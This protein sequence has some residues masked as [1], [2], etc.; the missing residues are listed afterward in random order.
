MY[1]KLLL[2][3]VLCTIIK[4]ENNRRTAMIKIIA[5]DM[6]GTLLDDEKQLPSNFEDVIS[7][8]SRRKINFVISSGRSFNVLKK[9]FT[10]HIDD[11]TFICDN[12]AYIVVG[13]KNIYTSVIDRQTVT[14]I[15]DRCEKLGYTLILCGKKGA[16]HNASE[17][18]QNKEISNYYVC[19]TY[20][21]D[22]HDCTDE[23]FKVAIFKEDGFSNA[24]YEALSDCFA[25]R[26]NVLLSG[27]HWVD[28]MNKGVSKGSALSTICNRFGVGYNEVMAF[29]DYLN[30]VDMLNC[31]YYSFAMSNA[32]S[33]VKQVANFITG[34]NNDNS[35]MK[36]VKKYCLQ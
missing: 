2:S 33:S 5:T 8:L 1:P 19:Q 20:L 21:K 3:V 6:D 26:C 11:L 10:R 35:V 23:I 9:Q 22:L 24:Q 28:I 17:E 29:G 12:G 25:D 31:A 30:D 16:W 27:S 4:I 7:D 14:D 32:H 34:S 13:G 36:E 18:S 15:I